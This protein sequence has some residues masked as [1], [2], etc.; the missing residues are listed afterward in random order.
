MKNRLK[1]LFVISVM[2]ILPF[3]LKAQE[4]AGHGASSA[5]P[6]E[7]SVAIDSEGRVSYTLPF[8]DS[9]A[10][11]AIQ[12]GE[13]RREQQEEE[14]RAKRNSE[15]NGYSGY[16]GTQDWQADDQQGSFVTGNVTLNPDNV[17]SQKQNMMSDGLAQ[18]GAI[19]QGAS[20]LTKDPKTAGVVTAMG[21][22]LGA[23]S[24][25]INAAGYGNLTDQYSGVQTQNEE[26]AEK[27]RANINRM[28]QGRVNLQEKMN[29]FTGEEKELERL[30]AEDKTLA[31]QIEDAEAELK[32]QERSADQA[33]RDK[34]G[35]R[36]GMYASVLTAGALAYMGERQYNMY[37]QMANDQKACKKDPTKCE[38]YIPPRP[39]GDNRPL[40]VPPDTRPTGPEGFDANRFPRPAQVAAGSR[41]GSNAN[42]GSGSRSGRAPDF[43][44]SNGLSGRASP[45]G[46]KSDSD[47]GGGYSSNQSFGSASG[48]GTSGRES[49]GSYASSGVGSSSNNDDDMNFDISQFI[50]S[51]MKDQQVPTDEN[52]F[53]V[54]KQTTSLQK[55]AKGLLL[56]KNSPSL[57][58]RISQAYQK[59]A[60]ELKEEIL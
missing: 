8:S 50:P 18:M 41:D 42:R 33:G 1:I 14:R 55:E 30:Q 48:G 17:K 54:A 46:G 3:S 38:G 13:E 52:G 51:W 12:R 4:H 49:A 40:P 16:F 22:G 35:N 29:N 60:H 45:L 43:L 31:L 10:Q 5:A 11:E 19:S 15:A 20:T 23:A 6:E 27:N 32:G 57:F 36:L 44:S 28:N 58:T 21:S 2:A 34:W 26:A 47:F 59:K 56:G 53:L 37:R 39:E 9:R 7:P 24:S 25:L